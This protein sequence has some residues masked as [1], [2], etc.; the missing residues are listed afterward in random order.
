MNLIAMLELLQAAGL[1]VMNK[2]L[3]ISMMP[4]GVKEAIMLRDPLSGTKVNHE[5]PG[6][7]QTEFQMIVRSSGN[8]TGA[9]KAAKAVLA[10]TMEEKNYQGIYFRYSRPDTLPVVYPLSDGNLLE[11]AVNMCVCYSIGE[12]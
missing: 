12:K 1:G 9:E 8:I 3:F 7:Y 11:Y 10:L 6:F 2:S 5:L 4:A